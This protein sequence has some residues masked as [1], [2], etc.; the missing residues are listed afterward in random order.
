MEKSLT[1]AN[2]VGA[3]TAMAQGVIPALPTSSQVVEFLNEYRQ[4]WS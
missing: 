2:A 3:I 4:S 1:W